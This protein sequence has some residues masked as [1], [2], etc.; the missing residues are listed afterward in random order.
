MSIK[1]SQ[2]CA[3]KWIFLSTEVSFNLIGADFSE[4]NNLV[5]DL[6]KRVLVNA[7]T[8]KKIGLINENLATLSTLVHFVTDCKFTRILNN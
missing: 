6:L 1:V 3:I 2:N 5:V 8:N 4:Q 7:K